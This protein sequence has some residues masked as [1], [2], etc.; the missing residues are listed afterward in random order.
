MDAGKSTPGVSLLN[1]HRKKFSRTGQSG[2]PV[3]LHSCSI[4]VGFSWV[5]FNVFGIPMMCRCAGLFTTTRDIAHAAK[6]NLNH[7]STVHFHSCHPQPWRPRRQLG[8]PNHDA[9]H[10]VIACSLLLNA[11]FRRGAA[12]R[13]REDHQDKG[14]VHAGDGESRCARDESKQVCAT[15]QDSI[16]CLSTIRTKHTKPRIELGVGLCS[17]Q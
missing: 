2:S 3:C 13:S 17:C 4:I 6:H 16:C 5:S 15:D 9:G 14:G 1:Y 11:I 7:T 8:V 12:T 10:T